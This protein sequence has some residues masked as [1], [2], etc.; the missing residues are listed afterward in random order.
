MSKK[1]D[2]RLPL[3]VFKKVPFIFLGPDSRFFVYGILPDLMNYSGM[4]FERFY[5]LTVIQ[6]I[7]NKKIVDHLFCFSF[8]YLK[9]NGQL[10]MFLTHPLWL[11]HDPENEFLE[12]LLET[13]ERFVLYT[14]ASTI[15]VEFHD[16]ISTDVSFPTSLSYFSYDVSKDFSKYRREEDLNVFRQ[17][18]FNE[19][20]TLNCYE[21]EIQN[22]EKKIE[23]NSDYTVMNVDLRK[24]RKIKEDENKF[25]MKAYTP[26]EKGP[27]ITNG[28]TPFLSEN[29][30]VAY[31]ENHPVGFLR[32]L[33]SDWGIVQQHPT[34]TLFPDLLKT[35]KFSIGKIFDWAFKSNDEKLLEALFLHVLQQMKQR[36][37]EN[38]QITSVSD[39]HTFMKSFLEK[40]DFKN[41]HMFK[42]LKKGA[43]NE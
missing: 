39:E 27:F 28:E 43:K 4:L 9:N 21:Q 35:F 25:L 32:W 20:I 34:P 41:I 8:F 13:V 26:S 38:C 7:N 17:H 5:P 29:I 30:S 19:E 40:Y 18:E 31:K 2:T 6:M 3:M 12:F 33:P 42:I 1:I 24:F 14:K 22:L 11:S 23:K 10:S 37:L 16:K 36:R 15:E